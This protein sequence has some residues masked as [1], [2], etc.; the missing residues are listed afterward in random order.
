MTTNKKKKGGFTHS[1]RRRKEKKKNRKATSEKKPNGAECGDG[2][3]VAFKPI[4]SDV[5]HDEGINQSD[6]EHVPPFHQK[7]IL[8]QRVS[9]CRRKNK[10]KRKT[11]RIVSKSR[12]SRI[13][14]FFVFLSGWFFF[15]FSFLPLHLA[16]S[17]S[18]RPA[19]L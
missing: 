9:I 8:H 15:F 1:E 10:G 3:W 4:H 16:R 6:D 19:V 12:S 14:F 5:S 18:K 7:P 2:F 17:S 11:K 13:P